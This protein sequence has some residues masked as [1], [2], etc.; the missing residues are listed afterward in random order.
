MMD[1]QI[2]KKVRKKKDEYQ[3]Q[4]VEHKI[5]PSKYSEKNRRIEKWATKSREKIFETS[6]NLQLFYQNLND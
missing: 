6:N 1:S 4:L 2:E 5:S 3:R